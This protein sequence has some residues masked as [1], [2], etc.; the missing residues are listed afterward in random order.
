M[1]GVLIELGWRVFRNEKQNVFQCD[2]PMRKAPFSSGEVKCKSKILSCIID[3]MKTKTSLIARDGWSF[4]HV[5][6]L[7]EYL[8]EREVE[9]NSV[10]VCLC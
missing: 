10:T 9:S 2:R 5:F 3:Y 4:V 1:E 8:T 7:S 6:L